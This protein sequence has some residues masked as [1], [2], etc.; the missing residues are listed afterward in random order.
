MQWFIAQN[1][2]PWTNRLSF[3]KQWVVL[4]VRK[5]YCDSWVVNPWFW[6]HLNNSSSNLFLWSN[7]VDLTLKIILFFILYKTFDIFFASSALVLASSAKI[8]FVQTFQSRQVHVL[9]KSLSMNLLHPWR[10]NW[11]LENFR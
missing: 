2:E 8:Y 11:R 6:T 4:F 9:R 5:H 3:I 1:E 7:L 10:V